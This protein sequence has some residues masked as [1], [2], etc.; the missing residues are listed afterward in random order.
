MFNATVKTITSMTAVLCASSIAQ[1]QWITFTNQ[2]GTRLPTGAGQNTA[3]LTTTCPEE[4][5]YAW[6]YVDQDG[7][8]DVIVVRKRPLSCEG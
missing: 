5:D 2:T 4:K 1:A 6:G 8:V 7:D 3:S